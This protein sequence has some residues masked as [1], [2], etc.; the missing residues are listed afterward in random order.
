MHPIVPLIDVLGVASLWV[1]SGGVWLC[2]VIPQGRFAVLG[3]VAPVG[4]MGVTIVLDLPP[5]WLV[6]I[7]VG[8]L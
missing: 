4:P 2:K 6:P 5:V 7:P 1:T 3:C 8:L